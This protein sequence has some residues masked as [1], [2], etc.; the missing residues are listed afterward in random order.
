M[1]VPYL[2]DRK[3]FPDLLRIIEEETGI[4][5]HLVEKDYWLVY[6]D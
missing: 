5:A 2:H 3:D 6:T 1:V 4:K